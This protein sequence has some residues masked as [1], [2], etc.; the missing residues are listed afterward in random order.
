MTAATLSYLY[1]PGQD[2]APGI[3]L[4]EQL[5]SRGI[6][7]CSKRS[8]LPTVGRI[9]VS[10]F[11]KVGRVSLP[12]RLIV[13]SRASEEDVR[14]ALA[15]GA[16]VLTLQTHSDGVDAFL[17][18]K[19]TLC[20]MGS[21]PVSAPKLMSYRCTDSLFCHRH[22]EPLDVMIASSKRLMPQEIKCD[23]LILDVC[24][25]M[26]PS[27]SFVD[28][29]WG[30]GIQ[31]IVSGNVGTLITTWQNAISNHGA[32][33][34]VT[35]AVA[36]GQPVG[37]VVAEYNSLKQ[38][39]ETGHRF[40]IFGSP[41]HCTTSE[42]A[43]EMSKSL[44]SNKEFMRIVGQGVARRSSEAAFNTSKALEREL[45]ESG[46]TSESIADRFLDLVIA[47]PE[48]IEHFWL[49]YARPYVE[50]EG[51]ACEYHA[52]YVPCNVIIARFDL[53]WIASR[54]LRYCPYCA[55]TED[56]PLDAALS[57]KIE[58]ASITCSGLPHG[59]YRG[60]VIISTGKGDELIEKLWS[61]TGSEH[62]VEIP[63]DY[64]SALVEIYVVA[65]SLPDLRTFVCA[66]SY[67]R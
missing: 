61:G 23:V 54:R 40:A 18:N 65:V 62:K 22:D 35:Q 29:R 59:L 25:G 64:P 13:G 17:G 53:P 60:V 55:L 21:W 38:S 30:F 33:E 43:S 52:G 27:G 19:L 66:R 44:H 36:M 3:L 11:R 1:K 56:A 31:L 24:W 8:S 14:A 20:P 15:A 46:S 48:S 67:R 39:R 2:N 9:D 49:P 6:S 42:Q 16:S 10:P 47:A 37:Q 41:S 51:H 58:R 28:P 5:V 4:T 26:Q 50:D 45:C 34:Y 57:L 32:V 63:E 7:R 12:D